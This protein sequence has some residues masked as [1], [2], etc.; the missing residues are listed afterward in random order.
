MCAMVKCRWR[1][2]DY[3]QKLVLSGQESH[4]A[5]QACAARKSL[6]PLSYLTSPRMQCLNEVEL[7]WKTD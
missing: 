2:E 4:L 6:N 1:S 3:I 7:L 5:L